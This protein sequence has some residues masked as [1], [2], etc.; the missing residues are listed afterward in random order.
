MPLRV[1]LKAGEDTWIQVLS[2]GKPV[3]SNELQANETKMIEGSE[4]VRVLVGNAGGLDI[5]LNGKPIGSI[6]PKGQVRV[7][8][9]T[10]SGF[11][12]VPRNPPMLDPL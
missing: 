9:L 6:G 4:K 5:S 12:I 11:Q 3:F 8:E 1:G 2:D 10:P 7:V